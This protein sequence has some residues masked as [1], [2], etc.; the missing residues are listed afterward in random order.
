MGTHR[1]RRCSHGTRCMCPSSRGPYGSFL[2]S[3]GIRDLRFLC[4]F[5][6]LRDILVG[7]SA[8]GHRSAH[9]KRT[10][11]R[12]KLRRRSSSRTHQHFQDWRYQN[13]YCTYGDIHHILLNRYNHECKKHRTVSKYCCRSTREDHTGPLRSFHRT[14][15]DPHNQQLLKGRS[16]GLK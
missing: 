6:N 16:C 12:S 1:R 10:C 4:S 7:R 8:L 11:R 2:H 9:H 5:G 14:H 15:Q 3:V 13:M